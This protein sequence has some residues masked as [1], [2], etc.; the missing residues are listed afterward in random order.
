M[1]SLAAFEGWH[2]TV[3]RM[4]VLTLS[5]AALALSKM[6]AWKIMATKQLGAQVLHASCKE[7]PRL[8]D[9]C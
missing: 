3:V 5:P 1:T 7:H 8:P 2:G 9:A 4:Y 6:G